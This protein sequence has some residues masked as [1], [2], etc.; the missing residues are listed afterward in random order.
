MSADPSLFQAPKNPEPPKGMYYEVPSKP[1]APERPKPIFPWETNQPKPTR[2]FP[3]DVS[4]APSETAF[5]ATTDDDD[6]Q[7]D[8]TSPSTPTIQS[9]RA[10]PFASFNRNNAWDDVPEIERYVSSLPQNRRGKVQVLPNNSTTGPL[11]PAEAVHSPSLEDPYSEGQQR[12]PSMKLTDFPTEIERPSLP[13]TPAPMRR[14]SFWGAERDA[15]G[16][17]P[18]AEG[19]P[20]QSEWDP[21]TKLAELQQRQS[22]VLAQSPASPG[23]VIPD[24]EMP[25]SAKTSISEIKEDPAGETQIVMA[26]GTAPVTFRRLDLGRQPLDFSGAATGDSLEKEPQTAMGP[27]EP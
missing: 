11:S 23:R 18:G 12:R 22:E 21:S 19:V 16:D 9:N 1:P 26:P 25:S 15:Q 3:G 7:T 17:L 2:V 20:E 27:T 6:T 4:T 24:R 13:V 14:P 8:T 10:E 5:S